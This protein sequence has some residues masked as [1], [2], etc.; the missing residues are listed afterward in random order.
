MHNN[1]KNIFILQIIAILFSMLNLSNIKIEYVADFLPLFDVMIIYYFAVLR[2]KIFAVWFLFLLGLISD[3]INGFPLGITS[4]SYISSVKLFNSLN[5]KMPI[6]ENFQQ[7]FIQF[8]AF[9]FSTLVL[10]WAIL[11]IYHFQIYNFTNPMIQL[12]LTSA[13]YVWLHKFFDYLYQKIGSNC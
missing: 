1:L 5:Q 4:L 8:I 3:S 6:K 11:S 9:A 2:P 12:V 10:K 7:I 13:L